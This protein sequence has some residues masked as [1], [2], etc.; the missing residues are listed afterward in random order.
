MRR[1]NVFFSGTVQ[2]VGFRYAVLTAAKRHPVTGWVRN[3]SDGRV[4]I[5]AESSAE[6][7]EF[8]IKDVEE[9]MSGYIQS[10]KILWDVATGEFGNFSIRET[11]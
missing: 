2:G 1:I 6:A 5:V 10:K 4:E 9:S 11:L 3:L 7:L 8:F